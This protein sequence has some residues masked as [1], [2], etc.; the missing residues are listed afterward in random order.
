MR[1]EFFCDSYEFAKRSLMS[2]LAPG[3]DWAVHPMF[4][5]SE[6]DVSPDEAE[7]FRRFVYAYERFIGAKVLTMKRVPQK[8][9]RTAYFS[10]E[11]CVAWHGHILFDPDTGVWMPEKPGKASKPKKYIFDSE[12]SQQVKHRPDHLTL[13]FDQSL[14]RKKEPARTAEIRRKLKTFAKE[15]LFS[16]AY[17]AQAPL[18][19]LTCNKNLIAKARSRLLDAGLPE[20]RVISSGW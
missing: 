19:V 9:E 12:L 5:D 20:S 8:N 3:E 1:M 4:T 2:W 14:P 11:A 15:E 17:V 6:D 16:I 18:L 10:D 13:V 7:A